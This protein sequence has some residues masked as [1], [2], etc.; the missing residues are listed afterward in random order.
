MAHGDSLRFPG[1]SG[2]EDRVKRIL[3]LRLLPNPIQL[4]PPDLSL[5]HTFRFQDLPVIAHRKQPLLLLLL[6]NHNPRI[7]L[8]YDLSNPF[9]RLRRIYKNIKAA[10]VQHPVQKRKRFTGFLH[11]Q[12]HRFSLASDCRKNCSCPLRL[13]PQLLPAIMPVGILH[14]DLI[15]K[16]MHGFLKFFQNCMHIS[17]L[18]IVLPTQPVL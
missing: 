2:C 17:F 3:R 1:R 11:H 4:L 6:C 9:I 16:R 5:E 15:R 18:F 7:Q 13:I 12:D 14:R 10:A 8:L